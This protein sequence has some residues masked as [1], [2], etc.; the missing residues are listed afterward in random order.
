V[1]YADDRTYTAVGN[2]P[3]ELSDKLSQ[4]YAVLANFLTANKL[5]VNDYNTHLL[6]M[7]T[8]QKRRFRH[9]STIT[10]NTPTAVITPSTVER[11]LGA[12][13]H[14]DMH[15]QEH[16]MDNKDDPLKSLNTR[17]TDMKKIS[18]TT[19]F[20]T[21]KMIANGIFMSKLIYLMPVWM[22]CEDYLVNALQV[23]Q[24]KVARLVTKQDRYNPTNVLLSI[25]QK[26]AAFLYQKVTSGTDQPKTRQAAATLAALAAAGVPGPPAIDSCE[27]L[28]LTMKSWCWS[29][30]YWYNQLPLDLLSE[31]K[32]QTFKTRLKYWVTLHVDC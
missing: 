13:V 2:N 22:G 32:L 25:N 11:L 5:K 16:I 20:K 19:S 18:K 6:V 30:V 17:A 14:Q 28:R 15:W 24:N 27:L 7:S 8:R 3:V 10:F 9:T 1:C 29:S 31:A 23:C 26:K 12:Q 21:R 4:K